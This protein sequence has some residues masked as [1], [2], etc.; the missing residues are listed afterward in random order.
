MRNALSIALPLRPAS[1]LWPLVLGELGFLF[2]LLRVD[3]VAPSAVHAL[4][5]F[6]RF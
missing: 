4:R 6:L 2:L 3:G 1:L 5:L